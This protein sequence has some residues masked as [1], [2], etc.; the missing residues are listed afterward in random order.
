MSKSFSMIC[1]DYKIGIHSLFTNFLYNYAH[2]GS[3]ITILFFVAVNA[4]WTKYIILSWIF[5]N[6]KKPVAA[7][8]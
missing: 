3:F 2:R 4:H 7:K 6:S 1:F 8:Y 5:V